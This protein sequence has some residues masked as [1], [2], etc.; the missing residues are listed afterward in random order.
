MIG[1]DFDAEEYRASG[2]YCEAWLLCSKP[3]RDWCNGIVGGRLRSP[4]AIQQIAHI[5]G[6]PGRKHY[7]ANVLRVHH[8]PHAWADSH[9]AAGRV[10][11]MTAKLRRGEHDFALWG[12]LMPYGNSVAGYVS[13]DETRRQCVAWEIEALREELLQAAESGVDRQPSW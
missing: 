1:I 3:I 4:M 10:L 8:A 12:R 6:G 5:I 2:T 13:E 9:G 11:L 7:F